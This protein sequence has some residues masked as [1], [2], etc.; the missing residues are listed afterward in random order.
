MWVDEFHRPI[1]PHGNQNVAV[2]V[3]LS[4]LCKFANLHHQDES[5]N[6]RRILPTANRLRVEMQTLLTLFSV[7]CP[8]S[9]AARIGSDRRVLLSA[10]AKVKVK[11][12]NHSASKEI[13]SSMRQNNSETQGHNPLTRGGRADSVTRNPLRVV[14]TR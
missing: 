12:S 9:F 11:S 1:F 14:P 13:S 10:C 6:L 5:F 2:E 7:T 4:I 8:C 3:L